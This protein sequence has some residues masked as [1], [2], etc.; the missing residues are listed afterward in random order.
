MLAHHPGGGRGAVGPAQT[1]D[2]AGPGEDAHRRRGDHVS[3]PSDSGAGVGNGRT[4]TSSASTQGPPAAG[5]AVAGTAGP[6]PGRPRRRSARGRHGA[7]RSAPA[8]HHRGRR[9]DPARPGGA[10]RP[11]GPALLGQRPAVVPA[12]PRAEQLGEVHG[13]AGRRVALLDL[14][15]AAEA[16]GEDDVGASA[17]RTAGSRTRS[18]QASETS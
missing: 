15:A 11:V 2:V 1:G 7:R 9:G 14:G 12:Q 13:L 5:T 8:R 3:V 17:S 16:V 18:A 10:G 4:R 6:G